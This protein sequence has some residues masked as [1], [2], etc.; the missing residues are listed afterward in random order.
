MF[1]FT[2]EKSYPILKLSENVLSKGSILSTIIDVEKESGVSKS[3]ISRYLRGMTVNDENRI[4]I[5]TAIKK[6]DYKKNP[7]AS[8]LKSSKTMSVGV[9]LPDITDSF[10][11]PIIKEFE[12]CMLEH[13]YHVILSDYGNSKDNEITELAAL[14]DKMV[15]GVVIATSNVNAS[16]IKNCLDRGLP[17][18][19][20]DRLIAGFSCDSITVDN[21]N[22]SYRAVTECIKKGHRQIA[23]VH[24]H[25]YTDSE[26]IKGVKKALKDNKLPI[27]D[28]YF[29]KLTLHVDN[30]EETIEALLD[31]PD[32]PSLIFCSNI[33]VGIGALKVRLKRK[34]KIPEDVSV[35]VFDDIST[36]PNHDYV[37]YIKPEFSSISQP[38][39]EIGKYAAQLLVE[40]I[41]NPSEEYEAVHIELKTR[42]NMT[43]SIATIKNDPVTDLKK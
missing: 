43:Q 17:V 5:D 34:L 25:F 18:I 13:G 11:P 22:A 12:H 21:F 39:A 3:T 33:Y 24:G 15:D 28:E 14:S 1:F 27:R 32:P 2:D 38:L 37:T 40:R 29:K 31:L 26:R 7:M 9:V 8:G 41:K 30:P 35:L 42:L 4:K 10:F 36:F 20:L 16:H 6:L 19:M 23:A